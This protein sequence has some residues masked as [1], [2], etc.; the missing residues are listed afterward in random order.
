LGEL[1]IVTE[2]YR[3]RVRIFGHHGE[4]EA[5]ILDQVQD[6]KKNEIA[7]RERRSLEKVLN[8]DYRLLR[9]PTYESLALAF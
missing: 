8:T 4:R 6:Y 5:D 9:V 7:K 1:V 3:S 2:T